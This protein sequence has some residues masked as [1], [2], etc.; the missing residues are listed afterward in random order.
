MIPS[1]PPNPDTL[2]IIMYLVMIGVGIATMVV[3]AG[4]I[5]AA[6]AVMF[7]LTFAWWPIETVEYFWPAGE[8][9]E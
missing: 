9:I 7:L 8:T 6:C 4:W 2:R 1:N 5:V 3:Q